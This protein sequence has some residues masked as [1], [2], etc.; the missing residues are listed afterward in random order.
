MHVSVE[1]YEGAKKAILAVVPKHEQGL[2]LE[3]L[4]NAVARR[5]SAGMLPT[6]GSASWLTTV[7]KLDLAARGIIKRIPGG[8]PQRLRRT[9]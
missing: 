9:K 1:R 4:P 6:T 7:V 2:A 8:V 5:L 3:D